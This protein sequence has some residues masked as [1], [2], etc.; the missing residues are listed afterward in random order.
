MGLMTR[1]GINLPGSPSQHLSHLRGT[2]AT[3][4]FCSVNKIVKRTS[5]KRTVVFLVP[6]TVLVVSVLTVKM[7]INILK[8]LDKSTAKYV[9]G[10]K[11]P[12]FW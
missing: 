8:G 1:T 5:G 10:E 7:H 6:S 2:E 12:D 4:S 3:S 11:S 9:L